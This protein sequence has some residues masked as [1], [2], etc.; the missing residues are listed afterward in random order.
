MASQDLT[1][2]IK[3]ETAIAPLT[4]TGN[5]V[6]TGLTI[7]TESFQGFSSL[8]FLFTSGVITDG[9]LVASVEDSNLANMSDAAVVPAAG[10]IGTPPTFLA[11][12]DALSKRVGYRGDK[13][14]VRVKLTQTG[15]TTGGI[16]GCTAVLGH[17]GAAPTPA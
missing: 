4:V 1:N 5:G 8:T 15:A 11:A 13:R 9:T 2:E 6:T 17:P 7:D 16:I 12:D 14:Y 3:S 10:L